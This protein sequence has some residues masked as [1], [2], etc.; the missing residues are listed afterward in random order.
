MIGKMPL[1]FSPLLN[2]SNFG[3]SMHCFDRKITL[4]SLKTLRPPRRKEGMSFC[5]FI[6][7]CFS[8]IGVLVLRWNAL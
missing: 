4:A 1:N 6:S 3:L 8:E 7:S 5:L 2:K